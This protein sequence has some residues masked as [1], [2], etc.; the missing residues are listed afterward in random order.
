MLG[1]TLGE[2]KRRRPADIVAEIAVHFRLKR[3]IGLG[4]R[5]GLFQIEN[6]RHQR[7]RD[8]ASA[9]IAEMPALVGT[10]AE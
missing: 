8:K 4:L 9:E 1:E 3:R 10:G 5:I 7:F 6:Q 2:I